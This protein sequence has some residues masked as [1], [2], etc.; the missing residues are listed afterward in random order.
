MQTLRPWSTESSERRWA[1]SIACACFIILISLPFWPEKKNI[2]EGKKFTEE[3][4]V[5]KQTMPFNA[6][7]QTSLKTTP[8][9]ALSHTKQDNKKIILTVKPRSTPTKTSQK[10]SQPI[11]SQAYFIQAG[12]FRD[13]NHAK[14]LQKKL[15]QK[16]WP[17][18][19]QKKK[20]LYAVQI[21]PYKNKKNANL[22]KKQLSYKEKIKGFITHHAYP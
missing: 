20:H 12:A 18:I 8:K 22:V 16:H 17:V 7:P 4:I 6:L 9:P 10:N 3:S 15:T 1:I 2:S 21:G 11:A 13:K 19:I 14:K 5:K